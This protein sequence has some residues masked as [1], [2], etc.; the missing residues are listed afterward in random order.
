M[1]PLNEIAV[2]VLKRK[3]KVSSIK[4]DLGFYNENHN[5]YHYSNLEKAFRSALAK[6]KIEDFSFHDLL[7]CFAT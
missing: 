6:A 5:E 2:T 7:H 1:I 4:S 3:S